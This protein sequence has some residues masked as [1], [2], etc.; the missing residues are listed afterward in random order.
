MLFFSSNNDITITESFAV[1]EN[2]CVFSILLCYFTGAAGK[3]QSRDSIKRPSRE[4]SFDK[5]TTT[6]KSSRGT[7]KG[8]SRERSMDKIPETASRGTNKPISREHSLDK[9]NTADKSSKSREL[10]FVNME[11]TSKTTP[12]QT[13]RAKESRDSRKSLPKE[14]LAREN[15][16]SSKIKE[17]FSDMK[18]SR[19]KSNVS[20]SKL[21]SK[22]QSIP[23]SRQRNRLSDV[24]SSN[25]PMSRENQSLDKTADDT[26]PMD[27]ALER[28]LYEDVL[29]QSHETPRATTTHTAPDT[30][31]IEESRGTNKVVIWKLLNLHKTNH[32]NIMYA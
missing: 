2:T 29:F 32:R 31:E 30:G 28:S 17:D 14:G 18:F 7:T 19:E 26:L 23:G 20:L 12:T 15:T 25:L 27:S 1:N 21:S 13:P 10:S 22:D 16:L 8:I 4:Q 5:T 3:R 6:E 9:I 24:M 11:S